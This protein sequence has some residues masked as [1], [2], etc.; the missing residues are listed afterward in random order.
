MTYAELLA[1]N[2]RL[3]KSNVAASRLGFHSD[4][5]YSYLAE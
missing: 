2:Q 4:D 1:D 5:I 3:R